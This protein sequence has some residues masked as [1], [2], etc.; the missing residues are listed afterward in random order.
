LAIVEDVSVGG[1]SRRL[2]AVTGLNALE[3]FDEQRRILED[4]AP[5]FSG[6]APMQWRER[7]ETWLSELKRYETLREEEARRQ[8][9]SQGRELAKGA[10]QVGSL[11]FVVAEVAAESSEALR[12]VLDGVKSSVD[13][14]ILAARH[15][16]RASVVVYFGDEVRGRGFLAKDVVKPLSRVIDGGGGGRD[17]LA[18]AG[19]R[20]P[21]AVPQLLQQARE[22][23]DKN[24]GMAG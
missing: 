23:I 5:S 2:E 24:F 14:A 19:G 8:R 16:E 11:K 7:L 12:E 3:R 17:D 9:E 6:V 15:G 13:A 1:G 4:L 20:S 10:R 22:W 18:Q 21:D